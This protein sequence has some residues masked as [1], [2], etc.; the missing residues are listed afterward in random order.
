MLQVRTALLR[1][2]G[3]VSESNAVEQLQ[4]RI[5]EIQSRV[6]DLEGLCVQ[7]PAGRQYMTLVR[8]VAA[9]AGGAASPGRVLELLGTLQVND[10]YHHTSPHVLTTIGLHAHA[11]AAVM[12][13][14]FI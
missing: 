13:L 4:Q 10:W 2:P 6:A 12:V 11:P 7:R 14:F 9:F 5:F 3:G 8:N 1:L